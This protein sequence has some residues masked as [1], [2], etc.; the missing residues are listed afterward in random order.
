MAVVLIRTLD[1]NK[2]VHRRQQ[3]DLPEHVKGEAYFEYHGPG[4][5]DT[6]YYVNLPKKVCG[7]VEFIK[8][9]DEDYWVKIL[10]KDKQWYTNQGGIL[11]TSKLSNWK[12]TDPQHPHYVSPEHFSPTL[13]TA[14][15]QPEEEILAGGVHHIATLQGSHPFTE[16]EPILPQIEAAVYQGIPIPLDTIP[17]SAVQPQL[18][19]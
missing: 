6:G 16:Q 13:Y 17:A 4:H 18:S 8:V 7:A 9:E 19:I 11:H 14:T 3:D 12:N 2:R 10:W 5:K 15:E 1:Q